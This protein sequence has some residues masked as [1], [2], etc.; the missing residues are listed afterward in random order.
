[1]GSIFNILHS[2][3]THCYAKV[4][5]SRLWLSNKEV[6]WFLLELKVY[7]RGEN[8][9]DKESG[10]YK[11]RYVIEIYNQTS[12]NI[13]CMLE[14]NTIVNQWDVVGALPVIHIEIN[15]WLE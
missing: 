5:E 1:M 14:G 2:L 15:N 9:V 6:Y 13:S 11:S 4:K 8:K 10:I 3:G 12:S 7:L